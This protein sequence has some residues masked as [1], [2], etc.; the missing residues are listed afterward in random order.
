MGQIRLQTEMLM[1]RTIRITGRPLRAIEE[2]HRL[3]E[4]IAA[5]EAAQ[6]E[7][8]ME[9]HILSALEDIVR[10]SQVGST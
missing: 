2:H 4:L 3:I 9:T 6:A 1:A 8:L 7:Q 10:S 5:R